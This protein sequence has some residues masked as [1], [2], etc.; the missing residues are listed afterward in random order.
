MD[1]AWHEL[2]SQGTSEHEEPHRRAGEGYLSLR[3]QEMRAKGK[4]A[5]IRPA[6]SR[7]RRNSG[8]RRRAGDRRSALSSTYRLARRMWRANPEI[9]RLLRESHDPEEARW[10]LYDYLLTKERE[11][12]ILDPTYPPLEW[13]QARDCIETFKNIISR[14]SERLAHASTLEHLWRIARERPK[15]EV[16]PGFVE[17]MRHLFLGVIG[18]SGI[19]ELGPGSE[20]F[21]QRGRKAA[22]LRSK[23]LGRIAEHA[24]ERIAAYPT[25]L[26]EAVILERRRNRDRLLKHFKAS[27]AHWKSWP[28]QYRHSVTEERTLKHVIELSRRDIS[29]IKQARAHHVP[30]GITPY[31]LSL[32]DLSPGANGDRDRPLR[33]QVIPSRHYVEALTAARTRGERSLDFML[34]SDTSP[35]DLIVRRY[36]MICILKPVNTCPQICVYCQRNWEIAG[37]REPR[38]FAG[39]EKLDGALKWIETNRSIHEVL[40]TGGD[41]LILPDSRIDY[42][43]GRLAEMPHIQRIRIGTRTLVTMPMRITPDL[44]RTIAKHHS[45]GMREI[46]FVTHF[47]HPLEVTPESLRGATLIR[48]AGINI[49]NQAVYTFY[50]SRRFELV[51]LRRALRRIG[52]DPYYT[53]STKGKE[54]TRDFRVPIARLL[55]ERKEEARL[56]PGTV[57]LDEPVYNVPR[58]GKN[59]LRARQHHDV[60]MILP[61]GRRVYEFHPWEKK[62]A[63]VQT[64]VDT[65]VSI[66][67]YLGRLK[68][69]GEDLEDYRTIWYYY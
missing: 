17:E 61:D 19:Y 63:P 43:L 46:I 14:R 39:R 34:E 66:W 68:R 35:H 49:Y 1:R 22:A 24:E 21:N 20:S 55:Q 5:R 7:E 59:Y 11:L 40:V 50:N 36:P 10:R 3:D 13:T 4:I 31:Y 57:R 25:G 27:T 53:F 38:S 8:D 54:E 26:D 47:E 51:A 15:L 16:T 12:Y 52:V 9:Y 56:S 30:F 60:I 23:E 67:D 37:I 2:T 6:T 48:K 41:P 45:P 44:V 69:I 64:Y 28:W 58:L 29:A 65:D 33:A 42:M 32:M 62:L 18:K